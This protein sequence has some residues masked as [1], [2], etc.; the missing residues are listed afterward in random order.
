MKKAKHKL[1]N[2]TDQEKLLLVGVS[3]I[4]SSYL[5]HRLFFSNT[6]S[7][8][9]GQMCTKDGATN[10]DQHI[11]KIKVSPPPEKGTSI[12]T[13]TATA[14]KS[15]PNPSTPIKNNSVNE[16][17]ITETSTPFLSTPPSHFS[18]SK[19]SSISSKPTSVIRAAFDVGSGATKVAIATI[20]TTTTTIDGLPSSFVN[21][22]NILYED[23]REVLL[24]HSLTN[25]NILPKAAT[26]QCFQVLA[27]FVATAKQLGATEFVGVAT[28]VFREALNGA[29]FLHQIRQELGIHIFIA[30]Q[31]FEGQIGYKTANAAS[32]STSKSHRQRTPSKTRQREVLSWDSG[33]GSFQIANSKGDMYGG[34]VGSSTCLQIM[35]E[36]Q[37]RAFRHRHGTALS[38]SS[39]RLPSANPCTIED[40]SRLHDELISKHMPVLTEWLKTRM[41]GGVASGLRV[42]AIGG[43]TCAFKMCEVAIGRSIFSAEDVWEAIEDHVGMDDE[44]LLELSF[45]QP[46][47]LLPKLVLIYTVMKHTGIFEI[48][49]HAT[50]GSTLGLLSTAFGIIENEEKQQNEL[51]VLGLGE[52]KIGYDDEGP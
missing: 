9:M 15:L 48:E 35:M 34:A 3:V 28:A 17:S 14:S 50:T 20:E 4:S 45:L 43:N 47:M 19:T 37:G 5:I 33:G 26:D 16:T 51:K 12:K 42:V 32:V 49:Y 10:D 21:V 11:H 22:G 27:E 30:S 7:T 18:P 31:V 41:D 23:N 36:L 1:N 46:E 52:T 29:D 8:T 2:L 39:S 6:N 24:R 25:D 38:L 13:N 44:M 40:C